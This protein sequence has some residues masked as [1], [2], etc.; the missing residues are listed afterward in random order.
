[1]FSLIP[2]SVIAT[3]CL[4]NLRL[5]MFGGFIFLGKIEIASLN[6]LFPSFFS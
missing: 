4:L 1:M 3:S 6:V 2:L 5:Q